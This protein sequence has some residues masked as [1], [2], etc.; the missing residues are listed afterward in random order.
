MDEEVIINKVKQEEAEERKRM[1]VISHPIIV[2][3]KTAQNLDED[4]EV[5]GLYEPHEEEVETKII[6]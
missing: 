3:E 4:E 6:T 1:V 5:I 2:E